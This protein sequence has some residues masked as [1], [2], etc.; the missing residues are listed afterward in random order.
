[1]CLSID[2]LGHIKLKNWLTDAPTMDIAF[3]EKDFFF[4]FAPERPEIVNFTRNLSISHEICPVSIFLFIFF[5]P[6]QCEIVKFTQ[7]HQFHT[8]YA[9]FHCFFV[10]FLLQPPQKIRKL[11]KLIVSQFLNLVWP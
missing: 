7:N 9:Q 2:I 3:W 10:F 6:E 11:P 1:M 4:V 5:A 8:K